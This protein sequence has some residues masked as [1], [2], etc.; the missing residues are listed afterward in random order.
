M[1]YKIAPICYNCK[2]FNAT[3]GII[4]FTFKCKA[5]PKG[6]PVKILTGKI[7]HKKPY[8]GDHSI[9]FEKV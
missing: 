5:F 9:Q 4:N 1:T 2:H 7:D 3:T 6:I 8:K